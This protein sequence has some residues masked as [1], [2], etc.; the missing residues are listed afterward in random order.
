MGWG[1]SQVVEMDLSAGKQGVTV[2]R[3]KEILCGVGETEVTSTQ[4]DIWNYNLHV[5]RAYYAGP[6][7]RAI[8]NREASKYLPGID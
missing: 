7:K 1:E 4:K 2:R 3:G 5:I 6:R 8:N